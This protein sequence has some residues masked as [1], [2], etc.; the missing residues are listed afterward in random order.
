MSNQT[1]RTAV[2]RQAVISA[3]ADA[4]LFIETGE[5]RGPHDHEV[6]E[7]YAPLFRSAWYRVYDPIIAREEN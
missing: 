3:K 4:R 6:P 2:L 1:T 5:F 7:P